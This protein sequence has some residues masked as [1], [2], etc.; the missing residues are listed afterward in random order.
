MFVAFICE[1]QQSF[2]P[3]IIDLSSSQSYTVPNDSILKIESIG[4]V[5]LQ[6]NH[7]NNYKAGVPWG[8]D[9]SNSNFPPN[10]RIN[11][12]LV[13]IFVN[14]SDNSFGT[15]I[16]TDVLKFPF[17]VPNGT[18]LQFDGSIAHELQ[19]YGLLMPK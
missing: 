17:W 7:P 6:T 15:Q 4:I 16:L 2:R 14:V 5:R 9:P 12:K 11:G 19:V 13:A 8:N 3:I 1:A 10:I 18:L